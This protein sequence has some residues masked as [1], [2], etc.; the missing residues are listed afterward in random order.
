MRLLLIT[1]VFPSPMQP[2]RGTFNLEMSRALCRMGHQVDVVSP[3]SWVDQWRARREGRDMASRRLDL[4]HGMRV[5]YPRYVFPPKVL[6][7]CYGWFMWRSARRTLLP[8]LKRDPPDAVLAYW[9]HPDGAVAVRIARKIGK[10][11]VVMVGGSDVLLLTQQAARRRCILR[12]L[13]ASDAVV[14]V[15]QDITSKLRQLGLDPGKIHV[16]R[17][18]VD[19][20][21]FCPGDRRAARQR[22][23]L[24][25]DGSLLLW[26]GRMVP[27]K[28]METLLGAAAILKQRTVD[29]RLLLVGS[30]PLETAL[31][32]QCRGQCLEE[33]VKFVGPML[34]DD[35]PDWY[36]AA[37]V[38][39]LPS[40]SEGVPNVLLESIACGTPFVASHVGGIA[41]IASPDVDRLV[42]PGDPLAL[43][44]AIEQQLLHGPSGADRCFKPGSCEIAAEHLL[45]VVRSVSAGGPLPHASSVDGRAT[46]RRG[47]LTPS[48]SWRQIVRRVMAASIPKRLFVADGPSKQRLVWLTF[49]D[50]PDPE[51]TPPLLDVLKA[52]HVQATFFVI[53][54]KVERHP[55]LVRRLAE[56]GH[57][58]GNHT[59]RHQR[60]DDLSQEDLREEICRTQGL[61]QGLLG[62]SLPLFRPPFGKLGISTVW[63]L[64]RAGQQIVLWNVDPKDYS[65]DSPAALA[66]RFRAHPLQSGDIV[67]LHDNHP[68]AAA[69]LPEVIREARERG[70][71]FATLEHPAISRNSGPVSLR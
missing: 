7:T 21:T 54:S 1:N 33:R 36:R 2:T 49:D 40:L 71:E 26:I 43:A 55:D 48:W 58:I 63:C 22:L 12:V 31:R 37:D 53:G 44:D 14:A 23:G 52:N 66:D 28:G 69:V 18:G 68:Y 59:F 9:A 32:H 17:R 46:S 13:E 25:Q 65:L 4:L 15:S 61:L 45:D 3:V 56:E 60:L 42:P 8:L 27:V 30:G 64:W 51:H 57:S 35:L 29:Y 47:N 6:R 62:K 19:A 39:V 20:E 38:T 11:C 50:G 67:L 24:P 16:G 70:L 10:P 5:F 34:H 41:E